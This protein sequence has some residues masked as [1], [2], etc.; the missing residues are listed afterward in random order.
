[1]GVLLTVI[2]LGSGKDQTLNLEDTYYIIRC[3]DFSIFLLL[4][5]IFFS[6]IY[7]LIRK[8]YNSKMGTFQIVLFMIPTIYF[9]LYD[10]ITEPFSPGYYFAHPIAYKWQTIY[11]PLS[12]LFAFLISLALF[13]INIG[14]AIIM[15]Y[16]RKRI[17]S[18]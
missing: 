15:Y 3:M 12:M 1:M 11:I 18:I 9:M 10:L 5:F 6:T 16:K 13:L 7:F 17:T 2:S 8:Y 14:L 4:V